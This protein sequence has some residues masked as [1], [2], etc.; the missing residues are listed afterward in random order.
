M[1]WEEANQDT[2]NT[3]ILGLLDGFILETDG[4]DWLPPI[5]RPTLSVVFSFAK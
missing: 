3:A 1:K 4:L 5:P 2:Q